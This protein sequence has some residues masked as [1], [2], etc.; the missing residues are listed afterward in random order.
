M[1]FN[2]LDTYGQVSVRLGSSLAKSIVFLAEKDGIE[3]L[4][5]MD[6]TTRRKVNTI[7]LCRYWA[8]L[9]AVAETLIAMQV[10]EQALKGRF[11]AY[12][13][14]SPKHGKSLI[15]TR[16]LIIDLA[17]TINVHPIALG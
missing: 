13:D 15:Y 5:R 4:R 17:L 14:V 9:F 12:K 8:D 1:L 16:R 7:G 10:D 11:I 2:D 6:K 3:A